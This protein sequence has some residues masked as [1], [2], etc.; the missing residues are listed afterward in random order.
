MLNSIL[1]EINLIQKQF[2]DYL[3]DLKYYFKNYFINYYK[4]FNLEIK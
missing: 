1:N 2:D 3:K 4:I